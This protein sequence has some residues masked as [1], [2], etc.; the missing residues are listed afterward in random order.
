MNTNIEKAIRIIEN[1]LTG[2]GLNFCGLELTTEDLI[3]IFSIEKYQY[4]F[5]FLKYL[6]L[7]WN[8]TKEP[9]KSIFSKLKNLKFA[10]LWGR[11]GTITRLDTKEKYSN[12]IIKAVETL[13]KANPSYRGICS[14]SIL[15]ILEENIKDSKAKDLEYRALN[16]LSK[17]LSNEGLEEI[18]FDDF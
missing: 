10:L 13:L 14:L 1:S 8:Q 17:E 18:N 4:F 15:H 12:I 11:K 2:T 7:S 3:Y 5:E 16:F 9:P 6:H